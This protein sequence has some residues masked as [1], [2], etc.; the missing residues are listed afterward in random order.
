MLGPI[1][2]CGEVNGEALRLVPTREHHLDAVVRWFADPEVT[3]YI[4]LR[5]PIAAAA[6]REWYAGISTNPNCVIWSIEL[7]QQH[8]G[9]C[10]LHDIAWVERTAETGI[11]IGERE[12]WGKGVASRVMHARTRWVFEELNLHAL[13]TKV[14]MPNEAS[15]R[16][17]QRVGYREYGRNPYA[18]IINGE[19]V[20]DWLGVLD[21]TSYEKAREAAT[22]P[23]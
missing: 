3:R 11:V 1:L 14:F 4:S 15:R 17:C 19:Y 18:R 20:E 5:F 13:F 2:P 7:G 9:Q 12:F 10:G 6:E 21:R 16:A 8:I 22:N 23:R